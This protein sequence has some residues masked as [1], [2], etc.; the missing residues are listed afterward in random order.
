MTAVYSDYRN[1]EF[2]KI[3]AGAQHAAVTAHNNGKIYPL[4]VAVCIKRFHIAKMIHADHFR[5][6]IHVHVVVLEER[7]QLDNGLFNAVTF[8]R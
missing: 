1:I 3:P 5:F 4:A 2:G 8:S 6:G 7:D